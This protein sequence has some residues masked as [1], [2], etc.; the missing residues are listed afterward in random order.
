MRGSGTWRL[1]VV[2]FVASVVLFVGFPAVDLWFS[3]LF[4]DRSEGRFV[5]DQRGPSGDVVR[6]FDEVHLWVIGATLLGIAS[7][8][9][10]RAP[11]RPQLR[12]SSAFLLAVLLLGPGLVVNGVLKEYVGRARP[13]QI[14][15]FGGEQRF[16]RAFQITDQCETNCAFTS[17]HASIGFYFISLVWVFRRPPSVLPGVVLGCGLGMLRIG[18]GRHYLS[19]VV[20]SFWV[21]YATALVCAPI[22]G[23]AATPRAGE[24]PD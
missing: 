16:T 4:F 5:W 7:S 23:P 12:R 18:Q 2:L 13:D 20:F 14:A 10:V 8:L 1:D 9:A 22:L 11:Y 19:D 17:G 6:A 21:V 15:A 3:G 24:A